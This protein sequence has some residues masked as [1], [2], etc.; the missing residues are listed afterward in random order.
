M[1]KPNTNYANLKDSY[2]FY[3]ISQKVNAYL[4]K[5]PNAHLLRLGIGDVSLPLPGAVIKALHEAVDDQAVKQTFHGYMPECGAPFLRETIAAH[6]NKRGV[7]INTDEVFV[8]SGATP[9][10]RRR[11]GSATPSQSPLVAIP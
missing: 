5:N 1:L 6:Y 8:S 4:E 11:Y 2:L 3:N 10:A 7:N 9:V